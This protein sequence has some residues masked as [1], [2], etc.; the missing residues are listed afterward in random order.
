MPPST[1]YGIIP[2]YGDGGFDIGFVLAVGGEL[3]KTDLIMP[4]P[5]PISVV[6][7]YA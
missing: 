7:T 2:V 3:M 5:M 6:L 1:D 4:M